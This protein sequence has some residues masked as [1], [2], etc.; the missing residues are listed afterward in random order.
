MGREITAIPSIFPSLEGG[1][2]GE[3]ERIRPENFFNEFLRRDT[4]LRMMESRGRES[5]AVPECPSRASVLDLLCSGLPRGR[6]KEG[7]SRGLERWG[8]WK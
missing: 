8:L 4:R 7:G 2:K 6:G 1:E 5:W 3:G